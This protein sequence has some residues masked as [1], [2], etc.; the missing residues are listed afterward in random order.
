M[1]AYEDAIRA[2]SRPY[3]PWYVVP[4]DSK[5]FARLVVANAMVAALQGLHL[6]F[7]K[8]DPAALKEME[9]VREALLAEGQ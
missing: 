4:A 9:K 8:V 1:A 2:T 7:P 6:Q 3:A 5:P